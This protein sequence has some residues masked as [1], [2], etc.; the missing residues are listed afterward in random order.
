MPAGV[1]CMCAAL[2]L[3]NE[4]LDWTAI[5]GLAVMPVAMWIGRHRPAT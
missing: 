2:L 3:L 5:L 1:L 4:V